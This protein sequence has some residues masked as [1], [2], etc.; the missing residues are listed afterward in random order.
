MVTGQTTQDLIKDL[1]GVDGP[2][3]IEPH[4]KRTEAITR[5]GAQSVANAIRRATLESNPAVKYVR[6]TATLDRRTSPVC[7][8]L[9]GEVYKKQDAPVPPLHFNCR[10]T[11][12]AHIPGRDRGSRSMTMMVQ[13][14]DGKV[15]S[16]GAYDPKIQDKL[17]ASQ[18]SLLQQNKS[19]KPPSYEDW[20]KGQPA[21]AQDVVLGKKNGQRFRANNGSLTRSLTPSAKRQLNAQPK[22]LTQKQIKPPRKPKVDPRPGPDKVDPPPEKPAPPA[23]T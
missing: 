21:S 2:G 23:G 20:L 7:R 4:L 1:K 11:L 8:S 13:G 9:D 3:L 18:K 15:R 6:Y 10:S 22:A 16:F 17:S 19:G 14:E 5:T 12:V